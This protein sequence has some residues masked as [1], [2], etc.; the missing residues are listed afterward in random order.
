ME[1][2]SSAGQYVRTIGDGVLDCPMT[3][4]A[5]ADVVVVVSAKAHSISVFD[6]A[7]GGLLRTVGRLGTGPGE[8]TSPHGV[9]LLADGAHL[10]VASRDTDS[11]AMFT[12][13]GSFVRAFGPITSPYAV[14]ERGEAPGDF[15][16]A[17]W[18]RHEVY[19]VAV[20]SG[21]D[22]VV[23]QR[24]C[25]SG[26]ESAAEGGFNHVTALAVARDTGVLFVVDQFNARCQMF[27]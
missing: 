15:C 7:F 17:S 19:A 21:S 10:L 16:V 14:V 13:D 22:T 6:A 9:T 27:K 26:A 23:F 25:G 11:V 20:G 24:V 5:N 12:L 4:D 1:H 2:F 8:L 3:V 18:A